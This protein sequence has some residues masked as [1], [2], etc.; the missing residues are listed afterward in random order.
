MRSR[1]NQEIEPAPPRYC[2]CGARIA[3][4]NLENECSPCQVSAAARE[5]ERLAA[6]DHLRRTLGRETYRQRHDLHFS[7]VPL[8]ASYDRLGPELVRKVIYYWAKLGDLDNV[9]DEV[10][11]QRLEVRRCIERAAAQEVIELMLEE[12]L[13]PEGAATGTRRRKTWS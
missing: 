7:D 9:A 10:G 8:V 2:H 11:L 12:G 3:R 4:D 6:D 5:R 13:W 1:F